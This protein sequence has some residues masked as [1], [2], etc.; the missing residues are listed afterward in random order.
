MR[1]GMVTYNHARDWALETL[2]SRREATGFEGVEALLGHAH[3]IDV[4]I[5]A[6]TRREVRRR[7]AD[8]SVALAGLGTTYAFHALEEAEVRANVDAT[9]RCILLAQ[10]VG[11]AG[12]R[13][14]PNGDQTA[15]GVPLER[16]LDQIGRALGECA[17]FG[18]GHGIQVRLEMHGTVAEARHIRRIM[19]AADHPNAAVCWNCNAVDVKAGSVAAD[20]ALVRRWVGLVHVTELWHDAYGVYPY[21]ELFSLLPAAGYRGFCCA[22]LPK[23]AEPERL[24][25]YFRAL[26]VALSGA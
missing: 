22:E 11:A 9:K 1:L 3:G 18:A 25:R 17:L 4:D 12:V 5:P 13:V 21:R 14:Q 19:E 15:A 8:S 24:M 23:S 16:T 2:N 6:A 20:W 26:F 7:F 10:D